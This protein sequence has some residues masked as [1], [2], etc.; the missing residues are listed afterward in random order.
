MMTEYEEVD[1]DPRL[2]D[3]L[4]SVE[5]GLFYESAEEC[6]E[7]EY[8]AAL[9]KDPRKFWRLA[10]ECLTT[11]QFSIFELSILYRV[12]QCRIAQTLKIS[13][14]AVSQSLKSSILRLRQEVRSCL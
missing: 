8:I 3:R 2:M 14:S 1:F 11:R 10:R 5:D 9:L 7:R 12:K 13:Q 4:F 6:S